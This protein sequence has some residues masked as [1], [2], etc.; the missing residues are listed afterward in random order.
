MSNKFELTEFEHRK[1]ILNLKSDKITLTSIEDIYSD[2]GKEITHMDYLVYFYDNGLSDFSWVE[3]EGINEGW[4]H[5]DKDL[6]TDKDI[7]QALKESINRTL[8]AIEHN[9]YD[10]NITFF[11]VQE[12]KKKLY[13]IVELSKD[14]MS[15]IDF[16][17]YLELEEN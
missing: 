15:R 16:S 6:K 14:Y 5:T 2:L 7:I 17:I 12:H 11:V 10:N 9:S 13:H 1:D 4:I 8:D 3:V